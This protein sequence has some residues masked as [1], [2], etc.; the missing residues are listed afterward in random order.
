MAPAILYSVRELEPGYFAY[1]V[2]FH[3]EGA[4]PSR[5]ASGALRS[6]ALAEQAA[7]GAVAA[8]QDR[9]AGMGAAPVE[10][11]R[12]GMSPRA[13]AWRRRAHALGV[14]VAIALSVCLVGAVIGAAAGVVLAIW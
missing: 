7:A 12:H 4:R 11:R 5:Q 13:R 3:P 6:E 14:Y 8:I 1:D 10:V 2:T 9:L